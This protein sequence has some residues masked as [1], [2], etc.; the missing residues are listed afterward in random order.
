VMLGGAA[1]GLHCGVLLA[2]LLHGR[3]GHQHYLVAM[4]LG[5]EGRRACK[6]KEGHARGSMGT[7][8]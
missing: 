3:S 6:G 5:R 1:T 8:R 4:A 7:I 2:P